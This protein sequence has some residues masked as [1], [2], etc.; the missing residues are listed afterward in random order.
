L[1]HLVDEAP[2]SELVRLHDRAAAGA[3][4]AATSAAA[5]GTRQVTGSNSRCSCPD[6]GCVQAARHRRRR[7]GICRPPSARHL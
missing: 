7:L 5:W 3:D 1:D 2:V 4:A 6:N